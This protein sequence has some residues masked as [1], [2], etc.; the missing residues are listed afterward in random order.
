MILNFLSGAV[1]NLSHTENMDIH[2]AQAAILAE[3]TSNT[4]PF[5]VV[6]AEYY[7]V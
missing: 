5:R 4:E 3:A 2:Y 7:N 1:G 6:I